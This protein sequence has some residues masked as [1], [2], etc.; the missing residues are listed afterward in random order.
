MNKFLILGVGGILILIGGYFL[1]TNQAGKTP[2]EIQEQPVITETA[3]E[4]S[5]EITIS[6]DDYSFA[7]STITLKS[8]EKIRLNFKNEGGVIHNWTIEGEGIST[9]TINPGETDKIVFTAP[10]SGEYKIFCSVPGHRERGMVGTLN[11]E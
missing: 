6:G 10:A 3:E 4:A 8:G 1:L 7:P 5:R 2:T 9:E 11:A